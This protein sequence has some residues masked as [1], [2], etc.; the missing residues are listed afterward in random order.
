MSARNI[1]ADSGAQMSPLRVLAYHAIAD[2]AGDPRIAEYAVPPALFAAQLDDLLDRGW[3]FV[4]LTTALGGGDP[5]PDKALLLTFD[6]AYVDLLEA[7]APILAERK[8]PA[9]V[10][11]ISGLVG[12]TNEWDSSRGAATLPLLDAEGLRAVAAAGIEV[13]SHTATHRALPEVPDTEIE[14]EVDGSAAAL[15]ALG[16]PAPRAFSYPFG[17][18]DP[19]AVERLDAAGYEVAFTTAWGVVG[20]G[21]DR[22]RVPRIEVHAS[23]TPRKLRAKLRAAGWPGRLR[24]GFLFAQGVRLDPSAR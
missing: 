9:V 6:D 20:P 3:S 8:I 17:R 5:V 7:A 19:R 21:T 10:F 14:A 13:G 23:D 15:A 18:V 11:A 1:A 16:L 24:D 4:D 22:R 12:A 2:L